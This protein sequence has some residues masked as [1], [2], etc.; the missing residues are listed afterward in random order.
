MLVDKRIRIRTN[1]Y[2]YGSSGLKHC[3]HLNLLVSIYI[4]YVFSLIKIILLNWNGI[5]VIK[6]VLA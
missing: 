4:L 2:R 1:N 5:E 6:R 3:L